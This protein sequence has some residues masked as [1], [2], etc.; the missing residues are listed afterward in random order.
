MIFFWAIYSCICFIDLNSYFEDSSHQGQ[1]ESPFP[2]RKLLS[3]LTYSW[4]KSSHRKRI[5][6]CYIACF[7]FAFKNFFFQR[8]MF[9]PCRIM[10]CMLPFQYGSHNQCNTAIPS[11]TLQL[12]SVAMTMHSLIFKL[13]LDSFQRPLKEI[14]FRL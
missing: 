13:N 2:K 5:M 11:T 8:S 9:V 14:D 10:T 1:T 4:R 7:Y 12:S 3:L 6:T